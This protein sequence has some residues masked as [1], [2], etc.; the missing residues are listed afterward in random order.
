MRKS[1]GEEGKDEG[2][3]DSLPA[4]YTS[5]HFHPPPPLPHTHT[6]T[7]TPTAVVI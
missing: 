7:L 2:E 5:A 4:H 1:G 3:G 6:H